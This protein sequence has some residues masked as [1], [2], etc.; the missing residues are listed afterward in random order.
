MIHLGR[1]RALCEVSD[2]GTIAAA[3]HALHL[4]P[5]AVSQQIAALE[6]EVGERLVEPEGRG[7]RLTHVGRVLVRE[8]D[9]VF[10]QVERLHAELARHADGNR[11]DLRVGA[12]ATAIT[13]IVAPAARELRAVAPGV[14]LEVIEAEGPEG[15]AALFRHELDVVIS[16]EAPGAPPRSD[17]RASRTALRA[18]PLLVA[19]PQDHELAERERVPLDALAGDPWVAPPDGWLCEQIILAGCQAAGFTPQVIHRAADWQA[20]VALSAAGLG[21]G[22]IPALADVRA[23]EGAVIRALAEPVPRRHIFAACRRGA[24]Q[25]PSIAALMEAMRMAAKDPPSIVALAA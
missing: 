24:E 10:A 7:V 4:T 20:I 23:Q 5:S 11:A 25:A 3:A 14:A 22:L 21:V 8:A 16:M 2:R 1:L 12:F 13:R 19:L 6:R 9:A 18:D 17:P 15:F